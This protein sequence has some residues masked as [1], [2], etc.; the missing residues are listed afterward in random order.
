MLRQDT[1]KFTTSVPKVYNPSSNI[2]FCICYKMNGNEY[3]D[4]N[5]NLNYKMI[6]IN[7]SLLSPNPNQTDLNS[8]LLPETR[9]STPSSIFY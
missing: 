1:F 6:C 8:N 4:N 9:A 2:E 5:N 7:P 3:W